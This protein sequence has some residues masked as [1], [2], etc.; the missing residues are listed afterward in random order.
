MKKSFISGTFNVIHPGHMRLMNYAKENSDYLIVGINKE[1]RDASVDFHSRLNCLKAISIVDEIV[2]IDGNLTDLLLDIKPTYVIKGDEFREVFNPESKIVKK[3]GG[4]LI[5]IGGD[6]K[7]SSREFFKN[8]KLRQ[9][10]ELPSDYLIKHKID[11]DDIF[12]KFESIKN[13]NVLV[14]GEVI[15]DEY[16]H[17]EP[18]GMSQEDPT[19]V[20][21]PI[22]KETFIGGAGIVASH[23]A[24]I[25]ASVDFIT[26]VG[27]GD[28]LNSFIRDR[29]IIEKV[30]CS[31][32]E[33]DSR[34]TIKKVRYKV[35]NKNL[36]KVS[37]LLD[38]NIDS[39]NEK[40]LL[41]K[42]KS[43]FEEKI[44]HLVI[45]SDFNYGLITDS[46]LSALNKLIDLNQTIVIADTQASSQSADIRRYQK[47]NLITPTEHELRVS[48][49]D[50]K[51]GLA[52]L[53]NK[54]FEVTNCKNLILKLGSEGAIILTKNNDECIFDKLPSLNSS[55]ID[56]SG[57]GDSMLVLSGLALVLGLS[58]WEAALLGSVAAA[59]QI[60]RN[61]NIPLTLDEMKKFLR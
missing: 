52:Y 23:A 61:G 33:D 44:I 31:M 22:K 27:K 30:N 58:I 53:A 55:P 10:I 6:S 46:L 54:G 13:I 45:I 5:F 47:M 57:A 60:S 36:L 9:E 40:L 39:E 41:H 29:L 51:S 35:S 38:H 59:I 1:P 34:P 15:V 21:S 26:L 25:G 50:S 17:C 49:N 3:Y 56:T 7:F 32:L 28:E 8:Y 18:L 42:I 11:L 48:L 16:I 37:H 12:R 43:I 24:S 20:V 4:K 14:L 19:I 2:I